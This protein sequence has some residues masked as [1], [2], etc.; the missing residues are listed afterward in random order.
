MF[1]TTP[2]YCFNPPKVKVFKHLLTRPLSQKD[3][4]VQVNI[5][6]LLLQRRRTTYMRVWMGTLGSTSNAVKLPAREGHDAGAII[7]QRPIADCMYVCR[8]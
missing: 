4:I 3:Y 1:R 5:V 6:P 8:I 7:T 2:I